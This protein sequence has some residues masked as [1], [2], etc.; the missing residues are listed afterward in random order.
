MKSDR[1][2]LRFITDELQ[3]CPICANN[4]GKDMAAH[5]RV[6]HSHLLKVIMFLLLKDFFPPMRNSSPCSSISLMN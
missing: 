3:V 1:Q 2:F 5:F 6:Q 4:L